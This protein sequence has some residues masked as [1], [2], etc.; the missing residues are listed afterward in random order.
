MLSWAYGHVIRF[1]EWSA[2]EDV[3]IQIFNHQ[4]LK[5]K[6]LVVAGEGDPGFTDDV[7]FG[8]AVCLVN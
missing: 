2:S 3:D 4:V 1:H 5:L 8:R 6:F 7:K